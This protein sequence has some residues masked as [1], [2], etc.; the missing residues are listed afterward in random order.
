[1]RLLVDANLSPV[2][3]ETL[4]EHDFDATHVVDH[5]LVTASDESIASFAVARTLLCLSSGLQAGRHLR[6]LRDPPPRPHHR[7]RRQDHDGRPHHDRQRRLRMGQATLTHSETAPRPDP[8]PWALDPSR[9]ATKARLGDPRPERA[10][11]LGPPGPLRLGDRPARRTLGPGEPQ[12]DQPLVDH[13]R[14]L[15]RS[16]H[17]SI[18]GRNGSVIRSR[19]N[20]PSIGRPA[21]R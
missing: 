7:R 12:P 5:G 6:R 19:R 20:E 13:V 8:G 16:A 15:V 9:T 17:S 10:P 11:R 18:F 14:P 4:G 2:V 1:M 21:S 3:A